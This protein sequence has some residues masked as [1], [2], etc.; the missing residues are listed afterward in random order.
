MAAPVKAVTRKSRKPSST[1]TR[2]PGISS[3]ATG[4]PNHG[5]CEP[6]GPHQSEGRSILA[7]ELRVEVS[8]QSRHF[9]ACPCSKRCESHRRRI[10][11]HCRTGLCAK[12]VTVCALFGFAR[13]NQR[14]NLQK[15]EFRDLCRFART[16]FRA[17]MHCL[18]A[19]S[20][21]TVA[22]VEGGLWRTVKWATRLV[23]R[24]LNSA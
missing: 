15:A 12:G 19:R 22:A 11:G 17:R 8:N 24:Q 18:P 13:K 23:R 6:S 5:L 1:I 21:P 14:P 7:G 10:R 4:M 3:H 20:S 2:A 16:R 9:L